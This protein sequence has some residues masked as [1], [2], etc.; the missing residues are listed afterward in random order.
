MCWLMCVLCRK[1]NKTEFSESTLSPIDGL[2]EPVQMWRLLS[3]QAG[4]SSSKLG[5]KTD[6]EN[7]YL[8]W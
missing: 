5:K 2:N 7:C 8:V 4:I 3:T 1:Q 6:H